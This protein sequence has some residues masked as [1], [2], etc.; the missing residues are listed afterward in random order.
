MKY[1]DFSFYLKK[2]TYW[3]VSEAHSWEIF[4]AREDK[5]SYPQAAILCVFWRFQMLEH[6]KSRQR[7]PTPSHFLKSRCLQL[8]KFI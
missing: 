2:K 4:S 1:Q 7:L 6:D 8:W 5:N 3:R